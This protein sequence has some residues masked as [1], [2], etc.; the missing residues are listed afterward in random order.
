M[1]FMHC[2]GCS[3]HKESLKENER[4]FSEEKRYSPEIV[5][6]YPVS[7]KFVFEV[8]LQFVIA[9]Q[10]I[11]IKRDVLFFITMANCREILTPGPRLGSCHERDEGDTKGNRHRPS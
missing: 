1:S 5:E 11:L 9:T 4:E 3:A 10:G 6:T 8:F 7:K 2:S